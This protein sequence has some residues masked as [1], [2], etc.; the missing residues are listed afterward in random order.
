MR[1]LKISLSLFALA[2]TG[3][4]ITQDEAIAALEAGLELQGTVHGGQQAIVGAH[5]YLLQAGVKGY[6]GRGIAAS[7]TN[8]SISLL[9]SATKL[10]DTHGYYVLTNSTGGFTITGDYTCTAGTQVYLYV[11]GG[12]PGA[13]TNTASGLMSVLGNC[14]T[15]GNFTTQLSNIVVNEATT[16]AAAYSL[17]GFATDATHI[18]SSGTAL[19]KTGIA[20]AFA[21][22]LLMVPSSTGVAGTANPAKTAIVPQAMMNTMANMLA[23]C[24]NSASASAAPCTTL[25][26][27]ATSG[28]TTPVTPTDTATA[29]IN[30]A[31]NPTSNIAALYAIPAPK[32]PFTPALTAAP[33]DFALT[34]TYNLASLSGADGVAIDASGNA[35]VSNYTNSDVIKLSPA[36]VSLG[37]YVGDLSSPG[38]VAIDK[39]GNAWIASAGLLIKV[40]ATPTGG[41]PYYTTPTLTDTFTGVAIDGVGD[42]W[43]ADSYN[44]TKS[45]LARFSSAGTAI[46]GTTGYAVAG[47][48]NPDWV[49]VDGGGNA[50]AVNVSYPSVSKVTS[51]GVSAS[52]TTGFIGTGIFE[53]ASIAIDSTG[54]AWTA[55]S[56]S[57][58]SKLSN[59]GAILSGTTGYV[60]GGISSP[61]AIAIDGAGNAWVASLSALSGLSS[62][63]SFITGSAGITS[64][65]FSN[66]DSLAIDGS[67]NIWV[68]NFQGTH[69]ISELIGAAAPVVTPIAAGLPSTPNAN[70]TSTLGTRP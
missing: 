44:Y 28:G 58:V 18:S 66:A 68:T 14:P 43:S 4:A 50:W 17:A 64:P 52:G 49:A 37:S 51:A 40:N 7:T 41:T 26:S 1:C 70:G 6:A 67:G 10:S 24:V 46:S 54:D 20:N 5:V 45:T 63:G 8:A 2:L 59:T 25:F 57:S 27:N 33:K 56:N 31:H 62:T 30:I 53:A 35:W 22:A 9:T 39:S 34:L 3:C 47:L 15:A 16:V 55:N 12:N 21:N 42:I 36:G 61:Q 11:L 48:N 29:A 13:G 32:S 23:S 69:G 60:G 19:A 38:A 65:A